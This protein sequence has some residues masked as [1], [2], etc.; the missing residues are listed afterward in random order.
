MTDD[1]GPRLGWPTWT[2]VVVRDLEAERAF[3]RDG[4]GLREVDA[5]PGWVQ[6]DVGGL[7]FEVIAAE[8]LPQYREP[9]FRIGFT[10][11]DIEAARDALIARGAE[12]ISGIE[13]GGPGAVNRWAYFRDPEGHVFEITQPLDPS[14]VNP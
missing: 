12:A 9:G 14:P 10:V 11:Q 6:F 8:D 2:G 4:A 5:G 3:Y 7:L 1:P 13:G